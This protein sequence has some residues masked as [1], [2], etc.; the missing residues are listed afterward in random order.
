M[1][2]IVSKK[3]RSKLM[4]K[5]RSRDTKPEWILRC[6]LHRL[7]FRYRIKNSLLPGCPDLVFPKFHVVLFVHGCYWHRHPGC[8]DASMPKS[9][10]DFWEKKFTENVERDRRIIRQLEILGW[11]I[12][13]VWECELTRKALET[14]YR[15]AYWL[16][17]GKV[18]YDSGMKQHELLSVAEKKIRYRIS[19]YDN[20]RN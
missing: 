2:D 16:S 17:Q 19:S 9:N 20:D 15:V 14:V 1:T 11:R 6:G 10:V 4:S 18:C 5:V 3:Q 12:L 8:K 7:G 13:V